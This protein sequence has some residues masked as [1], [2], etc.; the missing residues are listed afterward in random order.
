MKVAD[1][2]FYRNSECEWVNDV[3]K[4]T[5]GA[6]GM[7]GLKKYRLWTMV[8]KNLEV[9]I[10]DT[11]GSSNILLRVAGNVSMSNSLEILLKI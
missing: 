9:L 1:N 10:P 2:I 5:S 6:S 11:L 8:L 3:V 4:I 7:D